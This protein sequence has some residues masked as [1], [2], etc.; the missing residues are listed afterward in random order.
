MI[1]DVDKWYEWIVYKTKVIDE[2]SYL[3]DTWGYFLGVLGS[4]SV[5]S[6]FRFLGWAELNKSRM[7]TDLYN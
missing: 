4:S 2:S 3:L 7:L 5:K 6:R 1:S